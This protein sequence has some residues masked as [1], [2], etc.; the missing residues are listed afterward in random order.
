MTRHFLRE[1]EKLK[2]AILAVG[3]TVAEAL[4]LAVKALEDGDVAL[5]A[6]V[7]AGDE[8]IDRLEVDTEE[9]CLKIL[10]LH[11]PVAADLRFIISV[12]KINNELE[13]IGDLATSIA[14]RAVLLAQAEK[15]ENPFDLRPMIKATRNMLHDSLEALVN[16]DSQLAYK[17]READD[18]IDAANAEV[19]RR[20]QELM[21]QNPER[22]ESLISFLSISRHLERMA[23]HATNIAEE[24]LYLIEGQIVR[25]R[26]Y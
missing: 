8:E 7:I 17:V 1:I 12:L 10:A 2:Q 23:D 19:H 4:R 22:I 25:H 9:E 6:Q 14:K 15:V 24:V 13:R 20:A 26:K 21:R 16:L 3:A 5:A 11:Q 18:I